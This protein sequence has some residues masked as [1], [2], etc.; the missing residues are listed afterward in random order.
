MHTIVHVFAVLFVGIGMGLT[1]AHALEYPG[2][3]RLSRDQYFAVQQI[4]RPGFA[5]GG[6][7]EAVGLLATLWLIIITPTASAAFWLMASALAALIMA[8]AIYWVVAQPISKFWVDHAAARSM[9]TAAMGGARLSSS[10]WE[11]LRDRSELSHIARA[12]LIFFAFTALAVALSESASIT[13]W[14][15]NPGQA[16]RAFDAKF[17]PL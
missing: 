16:L 10:D 3:L 15:D 17:T 7:A 12:A 1:L 11:D 9:Q 8:H 14:F 2:K 4:C 13:R 5:V 6:L